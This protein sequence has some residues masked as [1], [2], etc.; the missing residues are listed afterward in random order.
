MVAQAGVD[1]PVEQRRVESDATA[2][3]ERFLGSPT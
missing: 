3:S 1:V 2:Q